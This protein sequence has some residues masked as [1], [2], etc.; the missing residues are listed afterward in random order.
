MFGRRFLNVIT[1]HV[2]LGNSFAL[3]AILFFYLLFERSSA[4]IQADTSLWETPI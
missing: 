3:I 1:P 4:S 2:R